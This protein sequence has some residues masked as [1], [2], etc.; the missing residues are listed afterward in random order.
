MSDSSK[1]GPGIPLSGELSR[2]EFDLLTLAARKDKREPWAQVRWLIENYGL[3]LLRFSEDGAEV[4][5]LLRASESEVHYP[6]SVSV[7]TSRVVD[8]E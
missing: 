1:Q 6:D 7:S 8:K 3:G 2:K 4:R 5:S